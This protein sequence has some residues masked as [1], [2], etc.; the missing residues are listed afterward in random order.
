[1]IERGTT[2]KR[3][4]MI[5]LVGTLSFALSACAGTDKQ[6]QGVVLGGIAGGLL[7]SQF[8]GGT[9]RVV[10]TAAGVL[11]GAVIGSKIGQYMDKTDRLE[12]QRILEKQPDGRSTTWVNPN[13]H[14]K[15]TVTP[16]RTYSSGYKGHQGPCRRY[17]TSVFIEGK[18][19]TMTGVACRRSNGSWAHV[20]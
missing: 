1:M 6:T 14:R 5:L 12:S 17:K 15:F 3:I 18:A 20:S 13:N 9:G 16:T 4:A 10:A 2:M 7:G 8:G 19:Q 11:A